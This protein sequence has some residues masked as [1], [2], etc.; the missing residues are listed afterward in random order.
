LDGPVLFSDRGRIFAV[1]RH[2]PGG[3]GPLTRLGGAFSRKRT[4]VYL[5]DLDRDDGPRLVRLSDLPSA[6]D[7][8]YAGAVLRDGSLWLDWYTSRIDRDYPWL[9]GM[10]RATEIRMGRIPLDALHRLADARLASGDGAQ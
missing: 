4:A 8:S 7:T 1:A 6:G 2:Q 9:L 10:V 5:I 3:R